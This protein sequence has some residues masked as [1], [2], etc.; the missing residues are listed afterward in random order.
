MTKA[1]PPVYGLVSIA[2]MLALH[3]LL[4]VRLIIPESWHW[5]GVLLMALAL[6]LVT[7]ISQMFKRRD[8]TIK[9]GEKSSALVTEGPYRFSRNPIY[10]GMVIFLAGFAIHLGSLTPWVLVPVFALAIQAAFIRME[11]GM[12]EEAFGQAYRE[13]RRRVRRWI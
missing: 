5:L 13:Y 8:T 2:V 12:L 3:N 4:P 6:I 7:V 11:E 9:P 10:L 1:N